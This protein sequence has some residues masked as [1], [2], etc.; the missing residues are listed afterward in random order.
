M[1]YELYYVYNNLL[2]TTYL[3]VTKCIL[4]ISKLIM[5]VKKL[6]NIFLNQDNPIYGIITD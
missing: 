1:I 4:M 3:C 2:N 6:K 5:Y